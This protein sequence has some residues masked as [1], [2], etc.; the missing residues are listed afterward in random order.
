MK[1]LVTG[2]AGYVGTVLIEELMKKHHVI[3]LDR[4]FFG[5]D[6]L[7]QK[8]TGNL[9]LLQDDIRWF[10][11]KILDNVDV[12]L[13]L[14]SLSNDPSSDLDPK[15][16]F[17]INYE[18]R[19][20]VAKLSKKH[21]V[22]KY[23]LA[24]SASVYGF[25]NDLVNE[26]SQVNPLT[27][28]SKAV[29]LAESEIIPLSD[30]TFSSTVL[31]FST[32][33]GISPRMR[34]DL[35]VNIMTYNLYNE[36]KITIN[37]EG[38]QM[39]PFLHIRDAVRAYQNIIESP[40]EKISGQIFNVGSEKQNY[41]ISDL[42]KEIGDSIGISYKI[43]KK[44]S[45]DFRSYALSFNKIRDQIGFEPKYT[46]KNAAQEIYKLLENGELIFDKK[47][48]TLDWYKYLLS[49]HESLKNLKIKNQIL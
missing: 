11:P 31:R 27:T 19:V 24:S 20:R 41:Q 47:M 22:K 1:I 49:N 13:D 14:A 4:F 42:A 23:V 26:E 37:G 35:S 33:Y 29:R 36:G 38:K 32:L 12:V 17:E 25:Q 15:K 5:I 28:Y 2:G 34:F 7:K 18:G 39:R 30:N 6:Y 40:S 21:G 43:E 8:Q 10:D 46:V 45:N 3:C 44:G 16:T 48:I 9:E